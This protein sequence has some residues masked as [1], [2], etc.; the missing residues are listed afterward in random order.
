MS[1]DLQA[2]VLAWLDEVPDPELPSV[3]ITDLGIVRDVRVDRDTVIVAL[4][5]TYAG[6]PATE[7]IAADVTRAL[8]EH[9]VDDVRI[10]QRLA[11]A[12]TTQWITPRGRRRLSAEGIAPPHSGLADG[13]V[14]LA[15]PVLCPR[16]GSSRTSELSRFGSTPC[17]ALYRCDDCR[18]PFDYVK[19]H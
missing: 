19:P 15:Q 5:P 9:G 18:E 7:A 6:C 10:E 14:V 11:P 17:K 2:R 8:H 13:V 12:W 3:S 4:T 16:C 1:A